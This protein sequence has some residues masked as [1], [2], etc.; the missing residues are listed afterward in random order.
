MIHYRGMPLADERGQGPIVNCV[1]ASGVNI[2]RAADNGATPATDAEVIALRAATGDT[3]GGETLES[4]QVGIEAR[5]GYRTVL[6]KTWAAIEVGLE[7]DRWIVAVGWLHQLPGRLWTQDGDVFHA[8]AFGPATLE[9]AVIADPL[10]RPV[11]TYRHISLAEI[12]TFCASG[13]YASL[14]I[15]EY[16]HARKIGHVAKRGA[17]FAYTRNGIWRRKPRV[18]AGFSAET[19]LARPYIDVC[20]KTRRMT[21]IRTGAYRGYWLDT[22]QVRYTE[23]LA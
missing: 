7:A 11:P 16:S 23:V 8:V 18:T 2:V 15:A 13:R 4:L 19:T 14:S 12:R 1:A 5:Y 17:F 20:G 3:Q 10:Q 6:A 22:V 9:A 21:Q